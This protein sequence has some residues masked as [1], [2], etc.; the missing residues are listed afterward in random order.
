MGTSFKVLGSC[1]G[2]ELFSALSNPIA[3]LMVG[4][5]ATVFVQSSS[6]STSIVVS[7]VGAGS[8]SVTTGIP[9]SLSCAN[10]R[11]AP[12]YAPTP[13]LRAPTPTPRNSAVAG[14][15]RPHR[16]QVQC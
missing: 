12:T 9:V 10:K 5:L 16:T 15:P 11:P 14:L 7:L 6:T 2:G 1:A 4:V 8:M 3:G 13:M